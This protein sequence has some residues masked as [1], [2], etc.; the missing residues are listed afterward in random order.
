M[1]GIHRRDSGTSVYRC[2]NDRFEAIERCACRRCDAGAIEAVVWSEVVSVLTN[3]DRLLALAT[4]AIDARP[5]AE[6]AEGEDVDALDRRIA[7][8]ERSL[9]STVASL[10]RQGMDAT[11]IALASA[12]LEGEL[13]RLREHRSMMAVWQEAGRDR[14]DRMQR[15]WELARHAEQLLGDPKPALK[16]RIL[17]LLDVQVQVTGWERCEA[18][19]GR[20][21]VSAGVEARTRDRGATGVN[22]P[23]CLRHRF[24]PTIRISGVVPDQPSLEPAERDPAAAAYPFRI[25]AVG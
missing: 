22:C 3:P 6:A 7:R 21:F 15:L 18:C 12:E 23:A 8:L 14:A 5:S 24:I 10:L 19:T 4:A 13:A 2:T 1:H 20:G 9:G 17:D 11:V 16:R 25:A